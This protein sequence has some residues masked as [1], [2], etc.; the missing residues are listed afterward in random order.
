MYEPF[1]KNGELQVIKFLQWFIDSHF[2]GSKPIKPFQFQLPALDDNY[3]EEK[4]SYN[5]SEGLSDYD[6]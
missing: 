1:F 6:K 4:K 2:N 3:L 5:L